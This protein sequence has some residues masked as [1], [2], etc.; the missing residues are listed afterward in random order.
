[1]NSQDVSNEPTPRSIIYVSMINLLNNTVCVLGQE[2]DCQFSGYTLSKSSFSQL[3]NE[4]LLATPSNI[5]WL[6]PNSLVDNSY[7]NQGNY[8]TDGKIKITDNGPQN[9]DELI[10]QFKK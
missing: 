1:M 10:N 2:N 8:D 7:T 3:L 9:I 5:N 4:K 6:Q